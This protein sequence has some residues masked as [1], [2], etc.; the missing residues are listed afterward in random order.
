MHCRWGGEELLLLLPQTNESAAMACAERMRSTL[1]ATPL[2]ADG[3]SIHATATFG[4]ATAR[5]GES[6]DTMV[7]RVDKALY[8]GKRLGLDRVVAS[9]PPVAAL[10]EEHAHGG[11][12]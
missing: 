6:L 9:R 11:R 8:E 4:V 12:Q 10:S 3:V 5:Y 7:D 2:E 1:D